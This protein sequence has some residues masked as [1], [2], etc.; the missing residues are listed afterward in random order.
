M[1]RENVRDSGSR[2]RLMVA[3]NLETVDSICK[4]FQWEYLSV[5]HVHATLKSNKTLQKF[6]KQ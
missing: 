5:L 6:N 1:F 4:P 2:D 3:M